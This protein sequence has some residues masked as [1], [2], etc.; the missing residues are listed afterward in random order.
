M[1]VWRDLFRAGTEIGA[2]PDDK[3]VY[4]TYLESL[5]WTKHSP[6]RC[7][8]VK[9]AVREFPLDS[10]IIKTCQHLTVIHAGV[11]YDSWDCGRSKANTYWTPPNG[12]HK[13]AK[14]A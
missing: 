3:R 1:E 4:G 12:E 5:G 10:A 11:H 8:K 7:G 2:M 13:E 6:M 14:D 9:Y